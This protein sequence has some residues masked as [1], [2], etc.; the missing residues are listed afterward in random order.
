M[1]E[2]NALLPAKVDGWTVGKTNKLLSYCTSAAAVFALMSSASLCS[3]S[4][5]ILLCR[6][7]GC[8]TVID[9][10]VQATSAAASRCSKIYQRYAE[11]LRLK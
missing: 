5:S 10:R 4:S 3:P 11:F 9:V 6:R 7:H 1:C 2:I 8:A